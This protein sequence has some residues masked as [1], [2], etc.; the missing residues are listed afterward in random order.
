MSDPPETCTT[1]GTADLE[2]PAPA[3]LPDRAR[4]RPVVGLVSAAIAGTMLPG[5]RGVAETA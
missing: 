2:R 4:A 1:F 5:F 3:G